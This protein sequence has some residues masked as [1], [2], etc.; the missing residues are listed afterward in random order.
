MMNDANDAL[1]GNTPAAN[2][3]QNITRQKVILPAS[4]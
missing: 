3:T 2:G 1:M 4:S